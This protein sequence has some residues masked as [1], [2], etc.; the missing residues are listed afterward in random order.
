M[1]ND[2]LAKKL[3]CSLGGENRK[4]I[5][6]QHLINIFAVAKLPRNKILAYRSLEQTYRFSSILYKRLYS[7]VHTNYTLH[8][9]SPLSPPSPLFPLGCH[10]PMPASSTSKS[11]DFPLPLK[12]KCVPFVHAITKQILQHRWTWILVR[13]RAQ[14]LV[15]RPTKHLITAEHFVPWKYAP[16]WSLVDPASLIRRCLISIIRSSS[17]TWVWTGTLHFF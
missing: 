12:S 17:Q 13:M 4:P 3:Y 1:Y 2:V 8:S 6:Y 9:I 15:W 11:H 14:P 10:V 7:T 16:C 5:N